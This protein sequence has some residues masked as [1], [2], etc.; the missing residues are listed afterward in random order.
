[1]VHQPWDDEI[2]G[3]EGREVPD[4]PATGT[5]TSMP[6]LKAATVAVSNPKRHRNIDALY[7]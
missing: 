7:L 4:H 1:M 5:A 2:S 3:I 6:L